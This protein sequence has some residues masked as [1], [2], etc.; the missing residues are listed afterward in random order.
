[1]ERCKLAMPDRMFG[2]DRS[3]LVIV[4][5]MFAI[6]RICDV[7][8]KFSLTASAGLGIVWPDSLRYDKLDF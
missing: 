1:M 2:L 6:I 7:N 4:D 5:C 8:L 3:K